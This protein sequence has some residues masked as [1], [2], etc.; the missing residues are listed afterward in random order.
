[1]CLCV[2][3]C[4]TE[5][6]RK[7]IAGTS[8]LSKL[9]LALCSSLQP[10]LFIPR[11]KRSHFLLASASSHC[12]KVLES[13]CI[14]VCVLCM[15][16]RSRASFTVGKESFSTKGE[17][18][19]AMSALLIR[20]GHMREEKDTERGRTFERK[21]QE[22]SLMWSSLVSFSRPRALTHTHT[23]HGGLC[24][25]VMLTFEKVK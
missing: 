24:P 18:T 2:C 6:G 4:S 14:C 12:S 21:R 9:P 11:L 19:A 17:G 5:K 22:K 3:L 10:D 1:M 16:E 25:A 13:V 8:P 20:T 15:S 7:V 23:Q